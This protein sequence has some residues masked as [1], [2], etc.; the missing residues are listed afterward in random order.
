[1]RIGLRSL[2]ILAVALGCSDPT[3]QVVIQVETDLNI[4]SELDEVHFVVMRADRAPV[5][6]STR[7][8]AE[9]D[10]PVELGLM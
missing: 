4:P 2:V 6:R 5:E 1:M 10:M 9:Q 3:T 8:V 7:L